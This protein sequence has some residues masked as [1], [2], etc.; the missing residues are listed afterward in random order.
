MSD[1]DLK[2]RFLAAFP[3]FEDGKA[4]LAWRVEVNVQPGVD[5]VR[6]AGML[7]A[8]L[9]GVR[10]NPEKDRGSNRIHMPGATRE[11]IT[12]VEEWLAAQFGPVKVLPTAETPRLS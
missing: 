6:P 5:E 12:A 9:L 3:W 1:N 10:P 4:R 11:Q 8:P 7:L 2:Q